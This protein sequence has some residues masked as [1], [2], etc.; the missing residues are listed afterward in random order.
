MKRKTTN[1]MSL[2]YAYGCRAPLEGFDE[3]RKEVNLQIGF[4]NRLVSIERLY[5]RNV[6]VAAALSNPV[7]EVVSNYIDSLKEKK[8]NLIRQRKAIESK[9]VGDVVSLNL[10]IKAIKDT[11]SEIKETKKTIWK[12]FSIWR[13]SDPD[14]TKKLEDERKEAIKIA[15]NDSGLYWGIVTAACNLPISTLI[16]T[17]GKE[18]SQDRRSC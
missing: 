4:W 5:N 15:R 12:I 9:A 10:I 2:V 14:G 3:V 18:I 7:L 1:S 8:R 6:Y 16:S 13:K 11:R 17:N